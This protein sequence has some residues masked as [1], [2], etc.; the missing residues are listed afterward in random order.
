M[1][2]DVKQESREAV[3]PFFF[4]SDDNVVL[5]TE[6]DVD[7]ADIFEE[8]EAESHF[9]VS[10]IIN[11]GRLFVLLRFFFRFF[12]DGDASFPISDVVGRIGCSD[13]DDE[14]ILGITKAIKKWLKIFKL[15]KANLSKD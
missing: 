11:G 8:T 6:V 13:D 2:S 15:H 7:T 3:D 1:L 14:E 4:N 9:S 12:F 10:C 5:Q